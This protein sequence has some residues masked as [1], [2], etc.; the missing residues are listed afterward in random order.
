M[1]K[2]FAIQQMGSVKALAKLLGVT[3]HAVYLW[4]ENV[5]ELRAY[6][7]RALRPDLFPPEG[8]AGHGRAITNL[9]EN[10]MTEL[11]VANVVIQ[12]DAEGRFCLHDLYRASG[13]EVRH[14]PSNWL[15]T[16]QTIELI[17]E[18]EITQIKA[19]QLN[20][21]I[22]NFAARELIHAYALWISP[23][24]HLKVIRAYDAMRTPRNVLSAAGEAGGEAAIDNLG[25]DMDELIK[26]GRT[27][28]GEETIKTV[29]ARELHAF[30]GSKQQFSHWI[31][32]R[33]QQYDFSEGI[34]FITIDNSIYSPP[35]IDYFISLD[36]AK[37][38]SMVERT[39]KGKEARRY[40]IEC[41][42]RLLQPAKALP[43][44]LHQI[45]GLTVENERRLAVL[46]D[47]AKRYEV[48]LEDMAKRYEAAL[49]DMAKRYEAVIAVMEDT[50]KRYEAV[51][52]ALQD[53]IKRN[54]A[55]MEDSTKRYEAKMAAFEEGSRFYTVFAYAYHRGIT[56]H[57]SL[58]EAAQ[59]N[60]RANALSRERGCFIDKVSDPRWGLVNAYHQ[61]VLETVF[62]EMIN[63]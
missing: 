24:F 33:I 18:V 29:N 14:K 62:E 23:A 40:F 47:T 50:I 53:T 38:L 28:I 32:A 2:S 7:L 60:T 26:V 51:I 54:E 57:L 63:A 21:V 41:E 37:E 30:L 20:P 3:R 16:Q 44:A 46:E 25:D 9:G 48:A 39:P 22:G 55:V 31:R 15:R 27:L 6:Q 4:K 61:D 34:D 5:S 45:S 52:A 13:G 58:S 43:V 10:R 17:N 19:I 35:T 8:G 1:K 56:A 11:T 42:K 59:V 49:E 12:Q 36:M